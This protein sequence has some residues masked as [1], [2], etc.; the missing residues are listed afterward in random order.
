MADKEIIK[1]KNCGKDIDGEEFLK[2]LNVCPRCDFHDYINARTRLELLTD[3]NSFQ[4]LSSN[5]ETLDIL[6]FY[7][8]KSYGERLTEARLKSGLDEA[9]IAG[10]ACLGGYDIS[11]GIMDFKFMGGSMGSIVGERIRVLADNSINKD[12]PLVIFS[13]S[14][15]ARMQEGIISLM[16]MAKTV[17]AVNR[18]SEARIP[19]FSILTNPT[20][21]GVSASF[22]TIA[23]IIIAEPG[24]FFCFAGPRVIKQTIKKEIPKDFGSPER[25]IEKGQIDMI[26]HRKELREKLIRLIKYFTDRR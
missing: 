8:T 13:A 11:L 14:G 16:Q 9:I 17:S 1:C 19:F 15:G 10:K 6:G 22:S 24:A 12:I 21:G 20:T 26:V 18:V 3:Q 5:I 2:N 4:E 23:D 25:I 7:D